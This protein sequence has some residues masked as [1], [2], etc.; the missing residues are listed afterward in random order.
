MMNLPDPLAPELV[1]G[2]EAEP[3]HIPGSVQRR[4][5][6]LVVEDGV[7]VQASENL[8][9]LLPCSA[10]G[11]V[12]QPLASVIGPAAADILATEASTGGPLAD[13]L[14][15]LMVDGT[16]YLA[17]LHRSSQGSLILEVEPM[18]GSNWEG[19]A[20]VFPETHNVLRDAAAAVSSEQMYALAAA[21]V[22]RLTGFDRVM[23]YVFDRDYN[24]RV[25]AEDS[26]EGLDS[27]LDLHFPASD[28]PAQARALY[29][30]SWIRL[31]SDVNEEPARLLPHRRPGTG[32]PTDLTF[33]TL[34]AVSPVH[35]E[36]LR[37]MG[38]R[39]SMS[40][41]LLDEGRLWGLVACHH[42]SGAHTP[43]LDV[44]A[45]V[46]TLAA[47]LSQRLALRAAADRADR[48]SD[49]QEAL[50]ELVEDGRST[51]LAQ[52]LAAPRLLRT[53]DADG[54]AVEVDGHSAVHGLTPANHA[55]VISA[56][57]GLTPEPRFGGLVYTCESFASAGISVSEADSGVAGALVVRLPDSGT[58]ALFRRE[59]QREV[60]WGGDPSEKRAV[61]E[62]DGTQRLGPRRSFAAWRERVTGSCRPWGREDMEGAIASRRV[63]VEMLFHQLR[64]ETGAAV[65]LQR[66]SLPEQLPSPEKWTIGACYYPAD[67]ARVGGDWYDVFELPSGDIALVVGD[68]AGHGLAAASTM[69]Q[70]R[71][72]LR[73]LL[74]SD[75]RPQVAVSG[76][77][78][79]LRQL[80]PQD[81]ATL[82]LGLFDPATGR[83]DYLSCG[84]P[85][86]MI[87]R[88]GGARRL[89][90]A[91]EL[92]L[93]FLLRPPQP[94]TF[95][96]QPDETLLVYSD[97]LVERRGE[98]LDRR[99][100]QLRENVARS[101]DLNVLGALMSPG[102]FDD[103]VTMLMVRGHQN[104]GGSELQPD[105]DSELAC[106]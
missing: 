27:F 2:C 81:M 38:V 17:A 49:V 75:P 83:V 98:S 64:S 48:A 91:D 44:R 47:G 43:S 52:R 65:A 57:L 93:G 77:D 80:L 9:E 14:Q 62:E 100:E 26:A 34:R 5:V 99:I 11:A 95:T 104:P 24:G 86:A 16:P 92:P 22:R 87:A 58:L 70:L 25:V 18:Q 72:G 37:N 106:L 3:I 69:S 51:P 73:S 89:G 97:G 23:V 30:K 71:N 45:A 55:E 10:E 36:Y 19:P 66:S 6:M 21:G 39:A 29:E 103:D 74:I 50:R 41:S 67:G 82:W 8:H 76:L 85:P 7:V 53:L 12:G 15:H 68:V 101:Q 33:A 13:S 46:E 63:L 60:S 94:L 1:A 59:A 32:D 84:H 56:V 28:I 78:R 42:Y 20:S 4:G 61:T 102:E 54:I 31:I 96:L 88:A 90:L 79:L 40:V 105:E 35:V